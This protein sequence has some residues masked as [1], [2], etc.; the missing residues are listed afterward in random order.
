MIARNFKG[1]L[2]R[3][4]YYARSLFCRI[5]DDP[6]WILGNQKS[7]TTAMGALL[8]NYGN[9]SITLDLINLTPAEL[10]KLRS[11]ALP[12]SKFLRRH[13]FEFSR[14]VIKEP[15]LTFFWDKIQP[16]FPESSKL[17][18]IRDPRDN[19]RSIL[20]RLN[21][22]GNLPELD[23]PGNLPPLWK[24]II[25]NRWMGIPQTHYIE[26]LA[27]RWSVAADV[28]LQDPHQ[29]VLARYEEFVGD[30]T[31]YISYLAQLLNITQKNDIRGHV[32]V[33]Y[34]PKGN[35][36]IG[37]LDFFGETNLLKIERICAKQMAKLNY[38]PVLISSKKS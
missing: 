14:D 5:K 2:R 21:L 26:S 27:Y 36:Q 29:F 31:G 25:D 8:A 13:A 19:I 22:K 24:L 34:Q 1:E 38:E 15:W 16:F 4:L 28:Y 32:D 17:F 23:N 12:V 6:V 30:K 37:W 20:N 3:M 7:G 9:L 10:L 33:Q 18:I 35:S 11:G